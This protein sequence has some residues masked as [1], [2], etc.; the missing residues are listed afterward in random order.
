MPVAKQE[1]LLPNLASWFA[2]N[3]EPETL[4]YDQTELAKI[5]QGWTLHETAC[6]A[7]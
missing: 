5:R 6:P 1:Q 4:V 3:F 2:I 7:N